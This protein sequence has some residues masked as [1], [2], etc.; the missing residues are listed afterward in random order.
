MTNGFSSL[1]RKLSMSW[2]KQTYWSVLI[3]SDSKQYSAHNHKILKSLEKVEFRIKI[4]AKNEEKL[5]KAFGFTQSQR[6]NIFFTFD[7]PKMIKSTQHF[8]RKIQVKT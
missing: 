4:K 6:A 2:A 5:Y 7:S 1:L 3:E 8:K